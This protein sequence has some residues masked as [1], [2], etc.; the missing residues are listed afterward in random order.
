MTISPRIATVTLA[1][2]GLSLAACDSAA[3]NQT[4]DL[5]EA[6]DESYEAEAGLEEAM[7]EGTPEEAEV[8]AYADDLRDEGEQ[9]KDDLEDAAD[10]MDATPQ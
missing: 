4:E 7:A 3:E 10:E 5:A 1:A 9:I 6:V 2:I 8:D